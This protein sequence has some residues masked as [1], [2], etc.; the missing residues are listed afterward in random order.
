M[1]GKPIFDR[2][3]N[4]CFGKIWVALSKGKDLNG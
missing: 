2:Q 3:C 4:P 1:Q